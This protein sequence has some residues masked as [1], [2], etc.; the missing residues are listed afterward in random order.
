MQNY[1]WKPAQ[2]CSSLLS[3]RKGRR[4]DPT[5][6][7]V[8]PTTMPSLLKQLQDA[9][10]AE[11][12]D[13]GAKG[14]AVTRA[15][16]RIDKGS[17]SLQTAHREFLKA[18]AV[19]GERVYTCAESLPTLETAFARFKK[20]YPRYMETVAMDTLRGEEYGHLQET[21]RVSLDYCG[22]GLF[23]HLQQIQQWE[24]SSFEL[25][26]ISVNL[27]SHALFGAAE[28]GTVE[29]DIRKRIM[30]YLNIQDTDYSMVFTASRGA[31]FKLLADA[32][33]FETCPRLITMYDYESE[34]VGWMV[35]RAREKGAKVSNVSFKWPLLRIVSTKLRKL[36]VA[37]RR[38]KGPAKGLF[39]FPVQSRISGAKYSYQ[40]M[41]LAQQNKWH[42]L[43]DASALGPK[44][45]DSLGLSLF[46]P[47]FIIASFYK[48]FGADPSGFGCL[49]IKNTAIQT[50]QDATGAPASG[51]VSMVPSHPLWSVSGSSDG[52]LGDV[53]Q[54]VDAEGD[55][56]VASDFEFYKSNQ[57]ASVVPSFSGPMLGVG[58]KLSPSDED[59]PRMPRIEGV[60]EQ[61]DDSSSF[62]SVG[63]V[64]RSPVFSEDGADNLFC[65]DIG[66]SPFG[67]ASRAS[68]SEDPLSGPFSGPI[69]NPVYDRGMKTA[70][71]GLLANP[72]F[73]ANHNLDNGA[74]RSRP[75]GMIGVQHMESQGNGTAGEEGKLCVSENGG[76]D[77][78]VVQ[79]STKSQCKGE[80]PGEDDLLDPGQKV[81]EDSVLVE[82]PQTGLKDRHGVS[83]YAASESNQ[84]HSKLGG[85]S[86]STPHGNNGVTSNHAHHFGPDSDLHNNGGHAFEEVNS[87]VGVDTSGSNPHQALDQNQQ[88]EIEPY[89]SPTQGGKEKLVKTLQPNFRQKSLKMAVWNQSDSAIRRETEGDFRLLGRRNGDRFLLGRHLSPIIQDS[90]H[91]GSAGGSLSFG[92]AEKLAPD[93][94]FEKGSSS[95]VDNEEN[96]SENEAAD[97]EQWNEAEPE[98]FCRGLDHADMLGLNKSTLR[99]RYLINWVVRSLLQLRHPGPDSSVFLVEL[100][101]PQIKYD[102]G[103][104]VAFNLYD[105]HGKMIH[106][107]LV[108]ML[109]DKNN[110]SVT[111]GFLRNLQMPEHNVDM[112]AFFDNKKNVG[113]KTP[114]GRDQRRRMP[115]RIEVVTAALS[116][117]SNFEDVYKLWVFLAKFLD[118]DFVSRELVSQQAPT[119]A[120]VS[121]ES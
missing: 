24:S 90:E 63:E 47:D 70:A 96:R 21:G 18:S 29:C 121:L 37:R 92:S 40:W 5:E 45:M 75:M 15:A 42:V 3:E 79:L 64:T 9:R 82:G 31:T 87:A 25:A 115:S 23:S 35:Q 54:Y 69:D 86:L 88:S 97:N 89:D 22:F 114:S 16:N 27:C 100:Y 60:M 119:E 67:T 30:E 52:N 66:Q 33:P 61:D 65:I 4:G 81:C 10:S 19:E 28:A 91:M 14:E 73:D 109:A 113:N 76:K 26:D 120:M 7:V 99:L 55:A 74:P 80:N 98:V 93:L 117:L 46:R 101:G 56:Q 111:I 36:L 102:R 44:D 17:K 94:C 8:E 41:S 108:Q 49:F 51:I 83:E 103:A 39:V 53:E 78:D 20:M 118:A 68:V 107:E 58:S 85:S 6:Q 106:P 104:A 38:R 62:E 12:A 57:P 95:N 84:R 116:V 105:C 34:S 48:V 77:V 71:K 1:L 32:Y 13:T 43:L 2:L 110:I 50:I 59:P 11:T 72:L 112:H